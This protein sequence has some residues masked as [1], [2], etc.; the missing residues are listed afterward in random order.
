MNLITAVDGRPSHSVKAVFAYYRE[1]I[2]A[3]IIMVV[4]NAF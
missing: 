3:Q 4:P 1:A 2:F